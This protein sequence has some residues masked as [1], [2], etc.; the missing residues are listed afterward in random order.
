LI[1]FPHGTHRKLAAFIAVL[2]LVLLP[3]EF[4]QSSRAQ[5]ITIGEYQKFS[6]EDRAQHKAFAI[7]GIVTYYDP[8]W[9]MMFVE[10]A[11]GTGL[12]V[13][14]SKKEPFLKPGDA[15]LLQGK[16]APDGNI[17]PVITLLHKPGGLRPFSISGGVR[18]EHGG[19]YVEFPAV[20]RSAREENG[21]LIVDAMAGDVRIEARVRQFPKK[22]FLPLIDA[23]VRMKGVLGVFSETNRDDVHVEMWINDFTDIT[24]ESTT[25]A[26]AKPMVTISEINLMDTSL[27]HRKRARIRGKVVS[28]IPGD[29]MKIVDQT[30]AAE[31]ST[32]AIQ[33]LFFPGDEVEVAGYPGFRGTNRIVKFAM[34]RLAQ[35]TEFGRTTVLG[36]AELVPPIEQASTGALKHFQ[37]I[38]AIRGLSIVEARREH[39]VTVEGIV[40]FYNPVWSTLFIDD[41]TGIYVGGSTN[42]NLRAGDRVRVEGRTGPG[43]FAPIIQSG[44]ITVLSHGPLPN[45]KPVSYSEL[46][47]AQEDSQWIEIE[48][49]IQN[50]TTNEAN[51]IFTVGTAAGKFTAETPRVAKPPFELVDT[52][53]TLHGVAGSNFNTRRQF[54]GVT[55]NVPDLSAIRV[56]VEGAQNP[57]QLP[58]MKIVDFGSFALTN[59]FGHR[60]HIEGVVTYCAP[61]QFLY[62]Q[63]GTAGIKVETNQRMEFKPGDLVE[64]VGFPESAKYS[65]ALQYGIC[66]NK[67]TDETLKP[68]RLHPDHILTD[69]DSVEPYDGRLVEIE[70]TVVERTRTISGET[71]LIDHQGTMFPAVLSRTNVPAGMLPEKGSLVRLVGICLV[72]TDQWQK[73]KGFSIS[74]R[75][76]KDAIVLERAPWWTVQRMIRASGGLLVIVSGTLCWIAMLRK[77]VREQTGLLMAAKDAAESASRAKSEFLATMSHEIRTPMN[78]II[79]MTH[80]LLHS[81]LD[82]E[83]RDYAE[84]VQASSETLL[85]IINDILDFSKI[86]AGKLDLDQ[87]DFDLRAAI[88]ETVDVLA[89]RAE[90]KAIEL[91]S[92][93]PS[94]I[95]T[96]L[97]GDS[98]RLRQILLNLLSNALKFT[99]R[100]EVLVSATLLREEASS[101]RIRIE[102]SD[103]GVGI[104]PEVLPRLFQPF[105]Q[106]DSSTTRRYGGTGLGLA[107]CKKLVDMMGGEIGVDSESGRG[108]KF[109]FELEFAKQ[110]EIIAQANPELLSGLRVLAVDDNA[111]N[112]KVVEN[113]VNRWGMRCSL[114]ENGMQAL[115]LLETAIEMNNPFDIALLDMQM[116]EM[117]GLMLA[118]KIRAQSRF[119]R[120][121]ILLLTSMGQKPS[122]ENREQHGIAACLFKPIRQSELFDALAGVVL[123]EDSFPSRLGTIHLEVN[124]D[125]P[126]HS[127]T[128][129]LLAEDNLVNQ[130]VALQQLKKLGYKADVVPNGKAALAALDRAHYP[131]VLMD[132]QMPEMDGYEATLQIREKEESSKSEQRVRIIAMT[133]DAMKGDREKCLAHGMDDY[134]AKP[135][136]L[137]D[138]KAMLEKHVAQIRQSSKAPS[139]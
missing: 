130:K 69:N 123:K 2:A 16:A 120:L 139:T 99:E 23:N 81:K 91:A 31:V 93:V 87:A 118:R 71:L 52:K 100:G 21:K 58:V 49:I 34:A 50:I 126:D 48:G 43:E 74:L 8:V 32:K 39:P 26:F 90:N 3:R 114:A 67:G 56:L 124:A 84:T 103:T 108:A 55:L 138:L 137:D 132:C 89:I 129:I 14:T 107:I 75:D 25:D 117:D 9:S 88:E 101:A 46:L 122:D 111:T 12:F 40:T 38:A 30:G 51:V 66:R 28:F 17:E 10:D 109:W 61:G 37:S 36:L 96:Q 70:G 15:I 94:E 110:T 18:K 95:P 121:Q 57:F 29:R 13:K 11:S 60:Q 68:F 54:K 33:E 115:A 104:S 5:V 83:Q 73:A 35:P 59:E 24:I 128:R 53:V 77:R 76:Y 1:A 78:G 125:I 65:P 41:G 105:T 47:T 62:V 97:K 98:V 135:V 22:T 131:I 45:A 113:F 116:P 134:L 80:L 119:K 19:R 42:G 127:E 102:V 20:F 92:F 136:R 72:E 6:P 106:A 112:R 79:G 44:K 86:E 27:S 63:D 64:A 7:E 133:A 85:T 82:S 4:A